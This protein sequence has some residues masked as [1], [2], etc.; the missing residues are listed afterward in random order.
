MTGA[1]PRLFRHSWG[2]ATATLG[3]LASTMALAA[4]VFRYIA[5]DAVAGTGYCAPPMLDGVDVY[6]RLGVGLAR[7]AGFLNI[8][9][10][11]VAAATFF[12]AWHWWNAPKRAGGD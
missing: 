11:V 9:A 6:C 12:A 7:I 10:I 2:F 5:R 8:G 3:I 4:A 1:L